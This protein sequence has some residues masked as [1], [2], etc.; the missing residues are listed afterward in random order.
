MGTIRLLGISG[1]TVK[2]GNCDKL[3]QEA[4]K[5]GQEVGNVETQFIT[6]AN[7]DIKTC[8]ICQYCIEHRSRCILEDDMH[9]LYEAIDQAD[10][11][12]AGSPTW[13]LNVSEPFLSMTSRFRYFTFFSNMMR[14]KVLGALT[15]SWWGEGMDHAISAIERWGTLNN[16]ITI[17]GKGAFASTVVFGK[18]ADYLENGVYDDTRGIMMARNIGIRV[19]EVAHMIK[20]ATDAGVTIPAGLQRTAW[21]GRIREES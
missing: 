20:Y 19:A 1:T 12:I 2:D 5:A 10:G 16:M 11:I 8:K 7:L 21:G 17:G 15:V 3:V 4:L 13:V 18:R 6:L 14:N 9:I